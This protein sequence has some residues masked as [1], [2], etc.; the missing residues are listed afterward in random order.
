MGEFVPRTLTLDDLLQ[1]H[2][3]Q[4]LDG[5]HTCM[6]G[7]IDTWDPVTQ[8]ADVKPLIKR[9]IQ[10]EDGTELL[11]ELPI[12][13]G[14]PVQ[15]PRSAEFFLSFPLHKGDFV[16]LHFAERS[17]DKWLS[18][19]GADTDPDDFRRHDLTDAIAVPGVAPFSRALKEVHT[20]NMVMGQ[21]GGLQMHITPNGT[22]EIKVAGTAGSFVAL[23]DVLQTWWTSTVKVWL[24]AH[25]HSTGVGP[26][27]PPSAASPAFDADIISGVVG[28]K[29]P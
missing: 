27:G 24:D 16:M 4:L 6:P 28:L 26:S 25:I 1:L 7:A 3:N 19:T 20:A 2:G 23:G 9:R 12:I 15:F 17:I 21:E 22:M 8:K 14:V 29:G 10:H 18:G 11:E 13:P 5:V